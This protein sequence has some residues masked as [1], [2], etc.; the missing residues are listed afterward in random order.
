MKEGTKLKARQ[1]DH[2][3][4]EIWLEAE[5][6]EVSQRRTLATN[7]VFNVTRRL[8]IPEVLEA[9]YKDYHLAVGHIAKL[10]ASN[11]SEITAELRLT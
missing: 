6:T 4:S 10:A 11:L 8:C 5:G 9:F 1:I 2:G 7:A 3:R